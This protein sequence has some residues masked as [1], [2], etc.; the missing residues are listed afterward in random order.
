MFVS[1]A[2]AMAQAPQAQGGESP[3][4]LVSLMPII[5][6]FVIFYFL[7]IR[8]QQKKQKEHQKMTSELKKNDQVVTSGGIHGTISNIKE[9]TVML[10]VDDS[11]K[12]EVSR[13]AIAGVKQ[14]TDS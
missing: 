13:S 9:K 6:M 4:P 7:L 8:P 11:V 5:F 10:K 2:Y 12:I 1:V 14:K 3:N